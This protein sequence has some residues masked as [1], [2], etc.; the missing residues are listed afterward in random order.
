[1]GIAGLP[2]SVAA[3]GARVAASVTT[4]RECGW[5]VSTDSS[6]I[7]TD[8]TAGQ[9]ETPL[10]V[11][12]DENQAA[13]RRSGT[14][15][16]NDTRL[17]LTQE[18]APCR[19]ALDR[20][21]VRVSAEG[22]QVLVT[23]SAVAGC[24]WG[25]SSD[26]MWV[27][28]VRG[29]GSGSGTAELHADTNRG[30]ERRASLTIAGLPFVIEQTAMSNNPTQSSPISFKG[31]V[32]NLT[33][34]CPSLAFTAAGRPVRTDAATHF[35]GGDCR[36]MSNGTETDIDGTVGAGGVVYA[37]KIELKKKKD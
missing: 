27:Q 13:A 11:V 8:P 3:G 5:T 4:T 2:G 30:A 12:V 20:P 21:G 10:T 28:V 36:D 23:V 16:I 32:A 17:T 34:S 29:G 33:G 7:R 14:I 31:T 24:G 19:Y 15:T 9:G 22:G 18:P 37:S 26:A 25:T 1:M 35:K 6:W